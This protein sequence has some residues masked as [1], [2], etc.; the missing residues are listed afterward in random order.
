MATKQRKTSQV[1]YTEVNPF[2][3]FAFPTE[4]KNNKAD[5][6]SAKAINQAKPQRIK[7][8]TLCFP[9]TKTGFTA[10]ICY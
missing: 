9:E 8:N 1:F 5:I 3:L 7:H 10:L 6:R 2:K 4:R